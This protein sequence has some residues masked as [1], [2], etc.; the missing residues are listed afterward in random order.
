MI[1]TPS[2]PH[3]FVYVFRTY[4]YIEKTVLRGTTSSI[5]YLCI[6]TDENSTAHREEIYLCHGV[7]IAWIT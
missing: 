2:H 7:F 3:V 1:E 5:Y 6:Y 4:N